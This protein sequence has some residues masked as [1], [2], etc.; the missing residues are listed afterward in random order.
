MPAIKQLASELAKTYGVEEVRSSLALF[1][2]NVV[3]GTFDDASGELIGWTIINKNT[4]QELSSLKKEIKTDFFD[5]LFDDEYVEPINNH[6]NSVSSR[7]NAPHSQQNDFYGR[8]TVQSNMLLQNGSN[9]FYGEQSN[10]IGDYNNSSDYREVEPIAA[11]TG[12]F[13]PM[14]SGVSSTGG[15]QRQSTGGFPRQNTG[16]FPM[17]SIPQSVN[18]SRYATGGFPSVSSDGVAAYSDDVT[19]EN[20]K[21][22][23]K[24][25]SIKKIVIALFV[26]FLLGG[27]AYGGYRGYKAYIDYI[28]PTY[29]ETGYAIPNYDDYTQVSSDSLVH[30]VV[31]SGD[32]AGSV[33][34]KM[35]DAGL[36][37]TARDFVS[38]L[39]NIDALNS[40][41][42]GDYIVRGN[43][44]SESFAYR[45]STGDFIPDGIIG[46]NEGEDLEDIAEDID[47]ANV[48]YNGGDFLN[49]A[50]KVSEWKQEFQM[51]SEVSNE[52]PTV[53]GYI[54]IGE[55]DISNYSDADELMRYLLGLTESE[56]EESGMTSSEW[57]QML[58]IASMIEKEALFDEDR[59][60]IS[61][62]I[63]NRL[64]KGM[65]LQIDATVKYANN[66]DEA[67][68]LNSDLE[69]DSPYNT[70]KVD[71]L[72]IGPI[73][74]PSAISMNAASNPNGTDYL[75]YVLADTEGHHVFS[76]TV[77]EFEE[78]KQAYLELFGYTE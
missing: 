37:S 28:T 63:A 36:V 77:A 20:D 67:R 64:A 3:I 34:Q 4:K 38:E 49:S 66:S 45:I 48:S 71:G 16:G 32:T 68:V 13:K 10:T 12:S 74:T 58:T 42:A 47:A 62:V 25:G 2:G 75:Y 61:S 7:S 69:I 55:Y 73:C 70:Y 54:L 11:G 27:L 60:D 39:L 15:F 31:E 14:S 18:E 33:R 59:Y 5:D 51:L 19:N 56:F 17:Q 57:H 35:L 41:T 52:L 29:D 76:S 65:K 26:L 78:D 9:S 46:V 44:S 72:P 40:I 24:S 22:K 6:T 21:T 50:A 8:E 30:I 53:E 23:K 43:E 1:R